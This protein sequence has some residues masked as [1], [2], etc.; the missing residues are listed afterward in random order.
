M[1]RFVGF[2]VP[3][4]VL[5]LGVAT[6]AL[7]VAFK[8]LGIEVGVEMLG[9]HRVLPPLFQLGIWLLEA[10][11]LTALFL[12]LQGRTASSFLDGLLSGW[13]AWIFRGPLLVLTVVAVTRRSAD[14]WW[15][16]ALSWLALYTLCG[17]VLALLARR[18]R[19]EPE[20]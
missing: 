7:E 9:P 3:S 10:T 16:M 1:L 4:L 15:S 5:T 14:L 18:T 2:A 8:T 13:I 12:I 19:L 20:L 11:G 17:M 6:F